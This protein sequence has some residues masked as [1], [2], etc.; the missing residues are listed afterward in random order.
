M[1]ALGQRL[2]FDTV[3]SASRKM[4]C[5]TCHDPRF[6][7]GPRSADAAI[8]GLR[9]I[10]SLR[11][12]Q[13]VSVFSEHTFDE[14]LDESID[15][16]PTGGRDWDGRADSLH[17]QAREPL[18]S[19]FE[20]ANPNFDAVVRTVEASA[21]AAEF[22]EVFGADVFSDTERAARALLLSLEVFQQDPAE[23]YPYTSRYDAWLRDET[24]LTAAEERGRRLF[25][26]PTKGNC[27]HCHPSQMRRG[28]FPQ[29]TDLG[30]VALGV[31]RNR[32]IAAN[33]DP[34]FFDLGLCGPVR[35]D[36]DSRREYCGFFRAP[37]LR[38]VALRRV[39]FHNGVFHRLTDAVAFYAERDR[40]PRRWYPKGHVDDLP[41]DVAANLNREPPFDR[42]PS[43]RT[44]LSAREIRD[45]VAFLETLTDADLV[46]EKP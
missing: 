3:L 5:A 18:T 19:P 7:W 4:A 44:A 17:D 28:A 27:A 24:K 22:R 30:Y 37:T 8:P 1:T 14:S 31:P 34:A 43:D 32:A 6:A 25:E 36:L 21:Y 46:P 35:K 45:I 11:Y 12:S 38:N 13:T 20:M 39:F 15:Q 41:A 40:H 26:D 42:K 10:P 9:A 23:F 16:G 29:F 2:F 33:A